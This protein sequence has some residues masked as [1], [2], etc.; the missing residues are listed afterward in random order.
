MLYL[1]AACDSHR[2]IGKDNEIPWNIK[3]DTIF[4]RQTTI[5]NTVI[6]G[7]NTFKSLPNGSLSNRK[8]IIMTN[9]VYQNNREHTIFGSKS[10]IDNY[11]ETERNNEDIFII[12]GQQIYEMYIDIA[13]GIFLTQIEKNYK[14]TT[15]FPYIPNSYQI[16]KSSERHFDEKSN[17]HFTYIVYNKTDKVIGNENTY[18]N[19]CQNIL[20]N[21]DFREDRTLVGTKSLFGYDLRFDISKSLPMLTTKTVPFKL[22]IEELLFFLRGDTDT[23]KLEDKNIKIWRGNTSK[24]FI[25]NKGLDY[26]EFDMGPMYGFQWRHWGAEY[27]GCGHDYSNQGI[28][29]LEKAI[30]LLKNDPY[31]RRIIISDYN[32]SDL[33]KGVLE[34]CHG[35]M[36]QF[37]VKEKYGKKY[38]SCKQYQRSMD[39]FLGSPINILS[40]SILVHILCKK[41]GMYPDT[42]IMSVGDSH[43]YINHIAQIKEQLD[44]PILCPPVLIVDDSV[45]DKKWDQITVADFKLIGYFPQPTIKGKMAV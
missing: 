39:M 3:D 41:T 35:N 17:V 33:N 6:M 45:K 42:L 29:Q 21:G 12:G 28:D 22:T 43:I 1:I 9:E 24:E 40:Y 18:L 37:F 30:H 36:I 23:K 16:K 19:L 38:L 11:I 26:E 5:G 44:R 8:N 2:G 31:S 27:K 34:N 7:H 4:F 10:F 25:Q 20:D 15:F 32:V 13:D 14:C